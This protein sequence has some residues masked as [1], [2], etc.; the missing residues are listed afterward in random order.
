MRIIDLHEDLAYAVQEGKD[1]INGKEQSSI[2]MIKS[3]D[4]SIIFGSIFPHVNSF[5]ERSYKL[6]SLYGSKVISSTSF[7]IEL[8]LEQIKFYYYLER[9]QSLKIIRGFEDLHRKGHKILLSLEGTDVLRDYNDLHLLRELNILCI[10][11]TW[12]YDTKFASCCISKKDYGL[13]D[14]GEELVRLANK[15]GVILDLAHAGK[16]TVLDVCSISKKPVIA[17]HA[18]SR[19]LKDSNRNLDDE[20]IE[21]IVKTRGVIG[22]TAI[23]STLPTKDIQGIISNIKYIGE[24]FGWEY[25][26]IGTDFLGIEEVPYGFENLLKLAD[27]QRMIERWEDVLWN[28][29]MRVIKENLS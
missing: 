5:D 21:A 20:E 18:N 26:A 16:R 24:S 19:R 27:L 23:T 7:S 25:V 28:N 12:N 6:A 15:L 8:L 10:G 17:S 9:I 11:L 3:F 13:T 22:I 4:E 2:S 1:V 14:E 29:A